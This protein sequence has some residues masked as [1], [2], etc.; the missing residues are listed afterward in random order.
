[1]AMSTVGMSAQMASLAAVGA[2]AAIVGSV[3][4]L[5]KA[6]ND[7]AK[8]YETLGLALRFATKNTAEANSEFEKL[9]AFAD[10]TPFDTAELIQYSIQLRNV[11]DGLFGTAE[12]IELMAGALAKAKVLGKDKTFIN[13]V[14]QIINAFQIGSGRLKQYVRTL[15]TTGAISIDTALAIKKLKD[16]GGNAAGVIKILTKEFL[17]SRGAA[18]AFSRTAEGLESTLL[19]RLELT[20]GAIGGGKTL[21]NYKNIVK[22]LSQLLVSVRGTDQFKDLQTSFALFSAEI[23]ELVKSEGFQEWLLDVISLVSQLTK[24]LGTLVLILNKML[25]IG[26]FVFND[27][28]ELTR[29]AIDGG[30]P[31]GGGIR[32]DRGTLRAQA[33]RK[34][35]TQLDRIAFS[36]EASAERINPEKMGEQ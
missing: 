3:T 5:G 17:R 36:S 25:A 21:E 2:F 13:S 27:F 20:L 12:N 23:F 33:G 31:L 35:S 6:A 15:Q 24:A 22:V 29:K 19:S 30:E 34:L 4:A 8:H 7:A 14:G 32:T 9:V 18:L 28:P 11:T 1:M 26:K 16:S 10:R